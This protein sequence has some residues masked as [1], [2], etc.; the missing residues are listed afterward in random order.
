MY[1][2]DMG[3]CTRFAHT[4][5]MTL[6][7][8]LLNVCVILGTSEKQIPRQDYC[9]FNGGHTHEGKEER[10]GEGEEDL[11]SALKA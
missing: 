10:A 8:H 3:S 11:Q 7:G 9:R 6:H 4:G 1:L 5:F 2:R